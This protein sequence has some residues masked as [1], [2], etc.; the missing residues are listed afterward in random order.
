MKRFHHG[1][2]GDTQ[3]RTLRHG[4]GGAHPKRLASQA[5]F[6]EKATFA[7]HPNG[8]LFPCTRDNREPD[9]PVL[10]AEDRICRVAL[11]ENRLPVAEGKYLASRPNRG[12]KLLGA[13]LRVLFDVILETPARPGVTVRLVC[14]NT[15]GSR[16]EA[17]PTDS[18]YLGKPDAAEFARRS[19][20]G[21]QSEGAYDEFTPR[22]AL[23]KAVRRIRGYSGFGSCLGR[24][25]NS[26]RINTPPQTPQ[27]HCD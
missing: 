17:S 6:S 10:H 8:G 14:E 11:Y 18:C 2:F 1:L 7:H 23:P 26:A 20:P 25:C 15:A 16:R 22:R 24:G 12:K 19:C 13:N 5:A 4:R 21:R 27:D 3:E 9:L